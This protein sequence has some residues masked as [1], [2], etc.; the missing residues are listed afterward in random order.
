MNSY[1]VISKNFMYLRTVFFGTHDNAVAQMHPWVTRAQLTDYCHALKVPSLDKMRALEKHLDLPDGWLER[2]IQALSK[3]SE[4]DF[5]LIQL[6]L[7]K[8]V[9]IK[10]A[11][12]TLLSL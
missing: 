6:L 1:T 4:D 5:D 9:N 3:M 8:P 10:A 12:K 11:V 2:D 7:R